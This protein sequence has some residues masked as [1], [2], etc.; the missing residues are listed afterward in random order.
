MIWPILRKAQNQFMKIDLKNF[1][2]VN[3]LPEN[4]NLPISQRNTLVYGRKDQKVWREIAVLEK[5]K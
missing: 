3:Y 1:K 5:N 2:I 4:L